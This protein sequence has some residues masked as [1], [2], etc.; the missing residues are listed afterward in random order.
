MYHVVQHVDVT[1]HTTADAETVYDL[2]RR[3]ET[4]PDWTPISTFELERPA[5][6]DDPEGVGAIRVFRLKVGP[7]TY[8]SR[9]RIVELVPGH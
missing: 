3:G 6:G 4:W 5:D 9:E 1:V 7:R 2:V 8:R